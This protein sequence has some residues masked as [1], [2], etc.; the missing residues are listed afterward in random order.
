M[1]YSFMRPGEIRRTTEGERT[2]I[3]I[4]PFEEKKKS[5]K[6]NPATEEYRDNV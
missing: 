5:G 6:V 3:N 1:L 4:C 2:W